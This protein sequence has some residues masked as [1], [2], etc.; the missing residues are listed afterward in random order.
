MLRGPF[1]SA[2]RG[3][4]RGHHVGHVGAFSPCAVSVTSINAG[5]PQYQRVALLQ[6]SAAMMSAD[7]ENAESSSQPAADVSGG[8]GAISRPGTDD[9]RST[10][11]A[12]PASASDTA[13]PS[14]AAPA[15]DPNSTGKT[16]KRN[17]RPKAAVIE[18]NDAAL[19]GM[20]ASDISGA[21]AGLA[22]STADHGLASDALDDTAA[23]SDNDVPFED[24]AFEDDDDEGW[25]VGSSVAAH[26]NPYLHMTTNYYRSA[27]GAPSELVKGLESVLKGRNIASLNQ[28]WTDMSRSLKDRNVSLMNDVRKM[29]KL[30]VAL[31]SGAIKDIPANAVNTDSPPLLYGP[32]ETL[33]YALHQALPSYGI[34]H[35]MLS[36]LQAALPHLQPSSMLDFG[37]GA[38]SAIFAARN[39][40]PESLFDVVVV[41]PSR[42][43][44]QVAEHMLADIPGVMY[45][46]SLEEVHRLHK[47]KKFDL[48]H[49][50]HT[51]GQLG[52]DSERD[53]TIAALWDL[54]NPGGCIVMS[55]HGDRWGFRV[56]KRSRDLLMHRATALAKFMPQ[57]AADAPIRLPGEGFSYKKQLEKIG[58]FEDDVDAV[59]GDEAPGGRN[60]GAAVI[61]ERST[62]PRTPADADD[63]EVAELEEAYRN[64]RSG[65]GSGGLKPPSASSS[66]A[67]PRL[68]D[69]DA[70]ND[71]DDGDIGDLT[72]YSGAPLGVKPGPKDA[73]MLLRPPSTPAPPAAAGSSA[74]AAAAGNSN[75]ALA[76]LQNGAPLPS[77]TETKKMLREYGLKQNI[78]EKMLR[79]PSDTYGTAVVGPCPHAKACPAPGNTWCH[80]AQAVNRHRKAG[81]SIHTRGLP[82]RWENF[83]FIMLRKTDGAMAEEH[84]PHQR[85]GWKGTGAFSL[86]TVLLQ[87]QQKLREENAED[88]ADSDGDPRI[89]RRANRAGADADNDGNR[90]TILNMSRMNLEPDNWWLDKRPEKIVGASG[91]NGS[92]NGGAGAISDGG[93]DSDVADGSSH[94]SNSS[95]RSVGGKYVAR[96]ASDSD[97]DQEHTPATATA[98]SSASSSST[99]AGAASGGVT[100]ADVMRATADAAPIEGSK[101]YAR[102]GSKGGA[103]SGGVVRARTSAFAPIDRTASSSSSVSAAAE[104]T[105]AGLEQSNAD[106]AA[107]AAS[108]RSDDDNEAASDNENAAQDEGSD[109]DEDDSHP[110]SSDPDFD[111]VSAL[112][113]DVRAAMDEGLPGSGQWARIVRPP[114]KRTGHVILDLC[115]PQGTFE[116]RIATKGKLK[117]F[118]GAYRSARKARWGALWPNW[119]SRNKDTEGL[120]LRPV[121]PTPL[122]AAPAAAA[123]PASTAAAAAL[124]APASSTHAASSSGSDSDGEASSSQLAWVVDAEAAQRRRDRIQN[125][126]RPS[127]K[128]RRRKTLQLAYNNFATEE[129]REKAANQMAPGAMV[130]LSGNAGGGFGSRSEQAPAVNAGGHRPSGPAGSGAAGSGA[131]PAA[132]GHGSPPSASPAAAKQSSKL[133]VSG[134]FSKD[135]KVR[136]RVEKTAG[137]AIKR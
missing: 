14:A 50:Q 67:G 118:P 87:R 133:D 81:R 137:K 86:D 126:P 99:G 54:L 125:H 63:D 62:P 6:S 1:S 132:G 130:D 8:I 116:R 58:V 72:N 70:V 13:A 105:E 128:A 136:D 34:A 17:R 30:R 108:H 52:S 94:V 96:W 28:H 122:L 20:D 90:I 31:A 12:D 39:I 100:L 25:G 92:S 15:S 97:S 56:I 37:A 82:R 71:F 101:A 66:S 135:P 80:F 107:A 68:G 85:A 114:L 46:R 83:S 7:A 55:E 45:R 9:T 41:E 65:G 102:P 134:I 112:E 47:N 119:L 79:P 98:S 32:T 74:V 78:H 76:R 48:I 121:A 109:D 51:L 22:A 21:R 44:T 29:E 110:R 91:V 115:T 11:R 95:N 26:S 40:W 93:S 117:P 35:R 103:G 131:G 84:P 42:S 104:S 10:L 38:G 127:R 69:V 19:E 18:P 61:A 75:S 24:E 77:L 33:A 106:A 60:S 4:I 123:L 89:V 124:P 120:R 113:D 88:G 129:D 43:M 53:T 64:Q 59:D 27:T 5:T 16:K 23:L 2:L 57:L 49:V 3:R 111:P 36:D 73:R